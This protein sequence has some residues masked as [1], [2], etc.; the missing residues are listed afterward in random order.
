MSS[1]SSLREVN[2]KIFVTLGMRRLEK[3]RTARV[4]FLL[5]KIGMVTDSRQSKHGLNEFGAAK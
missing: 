1:F 3:R 2:A 5:T 4:L